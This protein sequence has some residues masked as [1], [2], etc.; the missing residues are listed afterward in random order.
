MRYS[1]GDIQHAAILSR[2][3]GG[4]PET[5]CGR[6]RAQVEHDVID[7]A[8]RAADE[9]R[10]FSRGCLIVHSSQRPPLPIERNIALG[11]FRLQAVRGELLPAENPREK[12]SRILDFLRL[13]KAGPRYFPRKKDHFPLFSELRISLPLIPSNHAQLRNRDNETPPAVTVFGLLFD[14][15]IGPIPGEKHNEIGHLTKKRLYVVDR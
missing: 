4:L 5:E 12:T 13:Y 11:H 14:N 9:F 8:P 10:F 1:S 6:L 3:A 15:F 2:Q 7:R